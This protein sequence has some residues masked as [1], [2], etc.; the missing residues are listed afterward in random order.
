MESAL[1]GA[2]AQRRRSTDVFEAACGPSRSRL[3]EGSLAHVDHEEASRHGLDGMWVTELFTVVF[4][5]TRAAVE[6]AAAAT[7]LDHRQTLSIPPLVPGDHAVD[8]RARHDRREVQ[9]RPG[10]PLPRPQGSVRGRRRRR[11]APR[12]PRRGR[13]HRDHPVPGPN[14]DADAGRS[15]ILIGVAAAVARSVSL[16]KELFR[17]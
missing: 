4:E 8:G 5:R 17:C 7:L 6:H 15:T 13:R 9:R 11:Q 16:P 1:S 12:P 2:A 3:N 10:R 14:A